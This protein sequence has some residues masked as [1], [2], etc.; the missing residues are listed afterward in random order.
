[1]FVTIITISLLSVTIIR[2]ACNGT[3]DEITDRKLS[4]SDRR[5]LSK[6]DKHRLCILLKVYNRQADKCD[7][8]DKYRR[9]DYQKEKKGDDDLC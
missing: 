3:D 9:L 1:M 8:I 7:K 2:G 5:R 4:L 6:T